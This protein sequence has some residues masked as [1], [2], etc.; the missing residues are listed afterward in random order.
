V[1]PI[2][3]PFRG[4]EPSVADDAFIADNATLIGA[5]NIHAEASIWF[6]AVL[7]ADADTITVGSGSNVQDGCVI[8]ADP[9]FPVLIGQRVTVGHGAVVHGATIDDNVIIGMGAVVLNGAQVGAW[10]I[11]AAGAVVREAEI[12][13]KGSLVAGVPGRVVRELTADAREHIRL[14]ADGYISLAKAY[15]SLAGPEGLA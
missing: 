9:G 11:I 6:G 15:R 10:S 8:H 7:R 14:N 13:P 4:I 1:H 2:R 12:V 3:L 5:V